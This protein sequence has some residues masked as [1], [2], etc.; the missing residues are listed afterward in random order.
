M[1]ISDRDQDL[2]AETLCHLSAVT[3]APS[4]MGAQLDQL[5]S[6]SE[7]KR[8]GPG[9][10]THAK[11][12]APKVHD[13]EATILRHAKVYRLITSLARVQ[14]VDLEVSALVLVAL[15]HGQGI[16][17]VVVRTLRAFQSALAA[18]SDEEIERANVRASKATPERRDEVRQRAISE[19]RAPRGLAA[20]QELFGLKTPGA[21][22]ELYADCLLVLSMYV[23]TFNRKAAA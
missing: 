12:Q 15:D 22:A 1:S 23:Q 9:W 6:Q 11:P 4:S 7:A 17:R 16:G 19:Y 13:A 8:H 2:I 18:P 21:A 10:T 3:N 20:V 5:A 14:A